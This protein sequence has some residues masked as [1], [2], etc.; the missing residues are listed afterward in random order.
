M[1]NN[2]PSRAHGNL[3][4]VHADQK[5]GENDTDIWFLRSVNRGDNWTLPL[6]INFDEPGKHQFMPSMTVDQTTGSIYIVYYDRRAYDDLRTDVYLA[7]S[8]DGGSSFR[9]VKIS[10]TPFVPNESKPFADYINIVAIGGIITPIWTRMDD[11]VSS[12]WTTVI[13]DSELSRAK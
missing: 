12:V 1:V 10:E 6:R 3:Y 2:S 4:I 5:N 7:Y 8:F 9:E 13:K 11:G